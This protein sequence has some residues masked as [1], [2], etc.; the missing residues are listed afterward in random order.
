M[1]T[2]APDQRNYYYLLEGGRA[3]VHKPILAA[4]YAVHSQ[5]QLTDG[6]TGLG[7][8]PV[9]QVDMGEVDTFATQVQYAA[10]TLRSLTNGLAEQGWSGADIWDASVGRYSDRFLQVVAK[11]F[12]PAEGDRDAA[13]LEPTDPAALLQAYL[14]DISTDYSGAQLPQNLG[15]LDPALLAFAERVPPNYGRL[16][17]QRQAMVEAVRL[18]R[19]LNTAEAVYDA[20]SVPVVDQVP[21]EAALD[22]ALVA[23]MQS[24]ARY[25]AGYPN[26]REALIRLVQLW[27][28]MDAREEAIAW[29]LTHDPFANETNL[30]IIDPALIAFVQ[31][32]PD[33]YNGQ[34]DLRFALTE[35]YRRWFGLD[36]RTAAIQR[37]GVNPDDLAQNVDN[38]AALVM[39][40]RTLDRALL[41]FAATIPTTYTPTEDQREAL[42]RLVQVWRRLEGRI[43]AIQS[44]FEDLRRLERAAPSSPEAMPAPVPAPQPPRPLRW[45]PNNIQLDASIVPNGNFTW[46]EATR[47]GARMPPNQA[48]V[49]AMVRIAALAQQARDR[50]GRPFLITSW[51]RPAEINRRVGG[52]SRSRHI[53]G[54]AIDFYCLGLT[55][56]QVYWAL[57]PWWPGG[58]GRYSQFPALVH[59]DARGSKARWMH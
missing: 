45:T 19:Q 23:F 57:D 42:I 31:K 21:D 34:G 6:E 28:A 55:G 47:G 52:A 59:L 10:N 11:G 56:N 51:Y 43:P 2:L 36:S 16:D 3:G 33:L 41:D 26:Q 29:L 44:L 14:E 49:D 40:A 5:P 46:S 8:A 1:S 48:T 39:T 17:F 54:D 32:I 30:E 24:A 53:V 4:L 22:N 50:I 58:L 27:R 35:G 9:N 20:L 18:W 15:Q 7:I 13:Q 37:L 38:Q 12:T 25:Y